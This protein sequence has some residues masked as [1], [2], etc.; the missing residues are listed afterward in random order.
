MLESKIEKTVT[1]YARKLGWRSYK[2]NS[3]GNKSVPD[4]LYLRDGVCIFIEFKQLGKKPT[5]LQSFTHQ[6]FGDTGFPVEII[7]SIE[8]GKGFFDA[9]QK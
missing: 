2:F 7:D 8:Q 1:E 9:K 6:L 3:M 4:R 5:K